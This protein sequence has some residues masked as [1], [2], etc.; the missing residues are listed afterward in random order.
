MDAQD[1]TRRSCLDRHVSLVLILAVLNDDSYKHGAEETSK[2][3]H[4]CG[5]YKLPADKIE[6]L[7]GSSGQGLHML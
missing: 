4:Q 5:G 3:F 2:D 6:S 7:I 1:I